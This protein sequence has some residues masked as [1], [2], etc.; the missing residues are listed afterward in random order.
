[1]LGL[2]GILYFTRWIVRTPNGILEQ[3]VDANLITFRKQINNL[4][5]WNVHLTRITGSQ[6]ENS[7]KVDNIHQLFNW[8]NIKQIASLLVK[9]HSRRSE[10]EKGV[11][12]N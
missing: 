10:I 3:K 2:V 11:K 8:N 9:I 1:M 4:L 5:S 12:M 6:Y 7:L